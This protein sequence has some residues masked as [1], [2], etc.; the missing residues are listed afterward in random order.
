MFS[1]PLIDLLG[2]YSARAHFGLNMELE[3]SSGIF[4]HEAYTTPL[5]ILTKLSLSVKSLQLTE[6]VLS[7]YVYNFVGSCCLQGFG[8]AD[9]AITVDLLKKHYKDYTSIT[10]SNDGY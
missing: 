3:K 4:W 8:R 5:Q 1:Q 10:F 7:V 6:W 2:K 9:H